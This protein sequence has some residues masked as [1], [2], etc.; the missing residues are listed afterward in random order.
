V[1][2]DIFLKRAGLIRQRSL[3]KETCDGGLV[4]MDGRIA[5]AGKEIGT[6]RRLEID[7]GTERLEIEVLDLPPRNFKKEKGRAFYRI[8]EHEYKDGFS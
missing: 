8:I 2:L 5:K 3:A 7:L 1:R 6:G 4:K